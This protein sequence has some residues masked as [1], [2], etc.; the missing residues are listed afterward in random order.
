MAASDLENTDELD[1][2]ESRSAEPQVDPNDTARLRGD[3]QERAQEPEGLSGGVHPYAQGIIRYYRARSLLRAAADAGGATRED[4]L[5]AW[6]YLARIEPRSLPR[7][8]RRSHLELVYL[9][10]ALDLRGS[11]TADAGRFVAKV[12]EVAEMIDEI[13]DEI[14]AT[15]QE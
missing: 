5:R 9:V 12:H 4:A 7:R 11:E 14:F 1:V 13:I 10:H 15:E 2:T 6:S 8:I 3:L